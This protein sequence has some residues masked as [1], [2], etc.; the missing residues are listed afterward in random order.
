MNQTYKSG[1]LSCSAM[2]EE[3]G[4]SFELLELWKGDEVRLKM[5]TNTTLVF[6]MSGQIVISYNDFKNREVKAREII[7]LPPGCTLNRIAK[8]DC[9]L[10]YCTFYKQVDFCNRYSLE[11]LSEYCKG[12]TYDFHTL[13]MVE[14]IYRHLDLLLLTLNNSV[15]CSSQGNVVTS[16]HPCKYLLPNSKCSYINELKRQELLLMLFSYYNKEDLAQFFYPV[17]CRDMDFRFFVL[18]H[19]LTVTRL[20]D[21]ARLMHC[22]VST[23][24]RRFRE[25]FDE[26]AYHWLQRH[27]SIHILHDIRMTNKSFFDLS[28]EF[29]FSSQAHFS[30]FCKKQYGNTPSEIRA[31]VK[32]K[33]KP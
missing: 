31:G 32:I 3:A 14:M 26:P 12:Y 18:S 20:E 33:E 27:K 6:V 8:D 1:N 2:L 24:E 30:K 28:V 29:S 5:F 17:L 9:K 25:H 7:L 15:S 4:I 23:F 11:S 10:L 13:N 19:S 21:F 22:S 16:E